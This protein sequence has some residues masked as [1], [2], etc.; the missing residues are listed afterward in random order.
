MAAP[1]GPPGG[2]GLRRQVAF[3][4]F[5]R[6]LWYLRP[7]TLM[8]VSVDS[9]APRGE[10]NCLRQVSIICS[11]CDKC[12]WIFVVLRLIHAAVL[13]FDCRNLPFK[14]TSEEMY[15]IFGRFGPIRQIRM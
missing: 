2:G 8:M 15:D 5:C 1:G 9:S 3:L 13:F 10:P 7:M 11:D 12:A 14:I 6:L 4:A